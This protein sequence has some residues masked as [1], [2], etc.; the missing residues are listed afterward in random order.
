[1]GGAWSQLSVAVA[2]P[3]FGGRELASHSIVKSAGQV[4]L[5]GVFVWLSTTKMLQKLVQPFAPVTV[6]A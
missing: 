2:V 1:M 4:M 3:V 5:G 6:T